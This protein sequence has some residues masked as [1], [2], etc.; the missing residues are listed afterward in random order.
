MLVFVLCVFYANLA[1]II[2]LIPIVLFSPERN[3]YCMELSLLI[4]KCMYCTFLF[5]LAPFFFNS[6][7][8]PY[9]AQLYITVEYKVCKKLELTLIETLCVIHS[10]LRAL[11]H[12]QTDFISTG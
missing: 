11:M 7:M 9:V 5:T 10:L 1:G 6:P 12:L 8:L 2:I 4:D 3:R